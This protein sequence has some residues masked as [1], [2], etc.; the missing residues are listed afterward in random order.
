MSNETIFDYLDTVQNKLQ[1]REVIPKSLKLIMDYP[2]A[3]GQCLY[4]L[5]F[6]ERK[7]VYS[8]GVFEFLG[9]T[10]EEFDMELLL[11]IYHPDDNEMVTRLLKATLIFATE[12]NV[13]RDV[14]FFVTFRLRHKD[15]HY[16]RVLRQSNSFDTDP[17]GQLISNL[18]LLSDISFLT[19][20]N[21][22]EWRFQAPGLDQEKFKRYVTKE[23]KNFFSERELEIISQL[24]EGKTSEKIAEALCLSKHTVDTH[25]RKMLKKTG[26][27]N[28]I[29]LL[30]F[31]KINGLI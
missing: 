11:K 23:Y 30:N 3:K 17:N 26:C 14:A 10:A 5:N 25:R 22:V 7:L 4:L 6:Q 2:L 15:G 18:S 28:T 31:C 24:I 20:G 19:H 27:E 29:D 8:K 1:A 9:Y 21:R 12:N 16:I 13:S